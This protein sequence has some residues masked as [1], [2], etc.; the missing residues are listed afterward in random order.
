[1]LTPPG[2]PSEG[3]P[4][5]IVFS[6]RD[7][8][9]H[10]IQ[11]NHIVRVATPASGAQQV[12]RWRGHLEAGSD[13]LPHRHAE[14]FLTGSSRAPLDGQEVR[15]VACDALILP[16]NA[17]PLIFAKTGSSF[18]SAMPLGGEVTMPDGTVMDLL[19]RT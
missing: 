6:Q 13:T 10:S 7:N 1:M 11:G 9:Q 3:K 5:M 19:W 15:C 17:A 12:D 18:V 16:A 14:L 8:R 2:V 4:V